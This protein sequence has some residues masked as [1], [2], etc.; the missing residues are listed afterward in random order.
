[1]CMCRAS[2][3]ME[4]TSD[5]EGF[6]EIR[7]HIPNPITPSFLKTAERMLP[8]YI[9]KHRE[10]DKVVG[11]CTKCKKTV[12]WKWKG[13][14]YRKHNQEIHCPAC[15]K[16]VIL[17]DDWRGHE[18][19]HDII[20]LIYYY[21][22]AVDK[23]A[24]TASGA[25][26]VREYKGDVTKVETKI[27][28]KDLYLFRRGEKSV[29]FKTEQVYKGSHLGW[30]DQWRRTR[31]CKERRFVNGL[32]WGE[33]VERYEDMKSLEKCLR[34]TGLDHSGA[35][36]LY[37]EW[38]GTYYSD[39]NGSG[40]SHIN[41]LAFCIQNP[42]VEYLLKMGQKRLVYDRI[43]YGEDTR[44]I[45][46]WRG[47]TGQG[48]LKLQGEDFAEIKKKKIALNVRELALI[49]LTQKER[50]KISL[51]K[52][53]EIAKGDLSAM[54]LKKME[55][56][57]R[58]SVTKIINYIER[59][60]KRTRETM[61]EVARDYRDYLVQCKK[62]EM[63][64]KDELICFPKKLAERHAE[65]SSRIENIAS[66]KLNAQIKKN[67][68]KLNTIFCFEHNGIV[69]RPAI[70]GGELI[71]EGNMLRHCVGGYIE[72]YASGKTVICLIRRK[73]APEKPWY[74][75]EFSPRDFSC[76][77][78]RG[79]KNRHNPEEQKIIDAFKQ[80]FKEKIESGNKKGRK[81]A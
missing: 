66:A 68:K 25:V 16:E 48:V 1:M 80:A 7:R 59:Q 72:Q 58:Q 3:M 34:S 14:D 13:K 21:V 28:P 39:G 40:T 53:C 63:N 5:P 64:S 4:D 29:R 56:E 69:M 22:S 47:K 17:K 15:R 76:I 6:A 75:A 23:N 46:N 74:T 67:L 71:Y 42:C 24:L 36:Q 61:K 11:Y 57:T 20:Y 38:P 8:G 30:S 27:E 33:T 37:E 2:Y 32:C 43:A 60:A 77:Q 26:F 79:Y 65:L 9:F 52:A 73:E 45:V 70:D 55:R 12:K 18:T 35:M 54:D 49:Q 19:L 81:S 31:E 41:A 44:G 78:C 51:T 62:L 10:K 50:S